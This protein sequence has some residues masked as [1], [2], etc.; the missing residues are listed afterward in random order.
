L[1]SAN[2]VTQRRVYGEGFDTPLA[3]VASAGTTAYDGG[4]R[5]VDAIDLRVGDVLLLRSGEQ[6]AIISLVIRHARLPVYNFHVEE[7]HCYAVGHVQVLVHNNSEEVAARLKA[8]E[9]LPEWHPDR[10]AAKRELNELLAKKFGPIETPAAPKISAN[11]MNDEIFKGS[12]PRTV[13]RIDLGKIKGEQTRVHL[14]DGSA[15]NIDGTW[16][17]GGRTMTNAEKDWLRSHGWLNIP[18]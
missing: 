1:S 15:L 7:L 18:N 17:H 9:H 10:M 3:R 8:T 13:E 14:S 5:W 4:G 12:A 6:A 2:A 16:K 11:K